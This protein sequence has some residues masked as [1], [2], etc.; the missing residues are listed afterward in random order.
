MNLISILVN[1]VVIPLPAVSQDPWY[2]W[3][4]SVCMVRAISR[5]RP[6]YACRPVPTRGTH[7]TARWRKTRFC[8]G[9][10]HYVHNPYRESAYWN[11][12][13]APEIS[14]FV[15]TKVSLLLLE[16]CN[17]FWQV[18]IT[19][20]DKKL[21][22]SVQMVLESRTYVWSVSIFD[23]LYKWFYVFPY[24]ISNIHER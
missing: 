15:A 12:V 16:K 17:N 10:F 2:H 24:S 11:T 21:W 7:L 19:Q 18:K 14:A 13:F 22:P 6:I 20:Q 4:T 9:K 5:N 23:V 1:I 3:A 8:S